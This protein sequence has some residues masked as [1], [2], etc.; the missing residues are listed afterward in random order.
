MVGNGTLIAFRVCCCLKPF[1]LSLG[2]H[3]R[4]RILVTRLGFNSIRDFL[5]CIG[6]CAPLGAGV[7][8]YRPKVVL[9]LVLGRYAS[10]SESTTHILRDCPPT[11]ALWHSIIPP[12]RHAL[13]FAAPLESWVVSNIRDKL[14]LGD[15]S[16][17]WACFFPTLLWQ[18]W[19]RRND[20][21]FTDT[22]LPLVVVY[23][24]GLAWAKHFA[25]SN[26]VDRVPA[27]P[28]VTYL[29]WTPPAPGWVC[30]NADASF[31]PTTGIGTVRDV[32]LVDFQW[33]PREL[34]MVADCLSKLPSPS[35]FSLFVTTVIPEPARPFLD[36]DRDDPPY[37]RH[38]RGV[39]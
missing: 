32:L 24:L 20:F 22:C 34:N 19:K 13:F 29:Q 14:V 1:L 16:T 31:S 4:L 38:S 37:S 21:V 35:Q 12:E 15:D 6:L 7:G 30:L 23:K 3:L 36:R 26:E 11:R 27:T 2:F 10:H 8:G 9:G 39:T 33:I 5:C 25:G 28:L 18:L 17:P